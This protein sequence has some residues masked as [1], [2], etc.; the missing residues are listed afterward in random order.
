M[1]ATGLKPSVDV[2]AVVV[3]LVAYLDVGDG[4]VGAEGLEGA[5]ADMELLHDVLAVEEVV[6]D[7]LRGEAA[8]ARGRSGG[9]VLRGCCG[10][11]G[12]D[13]SV[14]GKPLAD[15]GAGGDGADELVGVFGCELGDEGAAA[16]GAVLVHRA[17][18]PFWLK[19]C[20]ASSTSTTILRPFCMTASLM[21][22]SL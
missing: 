11:R 20:R 15:E 22:V 8:G 1:A 5:G 6:E 21:M 12:Q 16:G 18:L 17:S 19:S 13:G 7:V 9:S 2:A 4:A 10:R 3:D 14:V